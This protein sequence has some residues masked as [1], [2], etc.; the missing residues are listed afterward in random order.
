MNEIRMERLGIAV[1]IQRM[2]LLVTLSYQ[3][4]I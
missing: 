2:T 3:N 4:E 1:D